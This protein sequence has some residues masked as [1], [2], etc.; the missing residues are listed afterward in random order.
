MRYLFCLALL[1]GLTPTFATASEQPALVVVISIDQLRR[2]RLPGE[3]TGGLKR[4]V[5]GRNYVDARLN[6]GVTNTCPGHVVLLTGMNPGRAGVPGN[7]FVDRETYE[8]RYCVD[9]SNPSAKVL[10][11]DDGRSPKNIRATTLGDWLK[12]ANPK[13][14]VFSVGGKDRSTI[15]MAGQNPDGAYWYNRDTG[16]FTTSGYYTKALPAYIQSF[17]GTTPELDGAVSKLP[18]SWEHDG[19]PYRADDFEGENETYS[20]KSGH[21]VNADEEI[22]DQ[23]YS[24]PYLDHLTLQ[25]ANLV[26]DQEQ[27]GADEHTDLLSVA[28]S[29]TDVVGH[30]YGPRSAE[31]IDALNKLDVWLGDFMDSLEARLGSDNI[32]YALSADHG[33]AELPEWATQQNTNQCPDQGRISAYGFL[34]SLY[35][36][37]YKEFNFPFSRPDKLV[38][39]GGSGFTVNRFVAEERGVETAQVIKWL[40]EYLEAQP[41]IKKA[42]T[43]T[44]IEDG[45]DDVAR[46]LRNS[47]VEDKSPDVLT[48]L[49]K[50]CVIT[51]EPGTTH[52]SVYD[53]DRDVPL[54]FYGWN[55]SP[56]SIRGDAYSVDM[57]PTLAN[58]LG[59]ATP[60]DLD[61]RVLSLKD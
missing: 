54:V 17:N 16:N 51:T 59:I 43:R 26:I 38:V 6:H 22:Y 7:S 27:L 56:G 14:K 20:R 61:G 11:S 4:L 25:V 55:V 33:V 28:L 3:F 47:I 9:D 23:V 52:G 24:S 35:W 12:A 13:T 42:W 44:E 31:S 21:P 10:D 34:G 8:P 40:D 18:A 19:S 49:E 15:A 5:S 58:H 30:R 50:D 39:F 1:V 60:H 29:A 57:G 2:D 48:Q 53:Y 36:N 46:L 32:L 41:V 45:T 37:V